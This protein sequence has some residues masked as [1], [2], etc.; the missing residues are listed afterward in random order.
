M[1][2]VIASDHGAVEMKS[3][4]KSLLLAEGHEVE[5]L[6]CREGESVDYPVIGALAAKAVSEGRVQRGV[7]LCGTGIGMSLVANRF[8]GVRATLV[9]DAYTARMSREHNDS[10]MLVLGGRVL[11]TEV[12]K[13]IVKIWLSTPFEG[14]RH[15]RRLDMIHDLEKTD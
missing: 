11:G 5:D 15:Q 14:G 13:D 2:L 1:K 6:G 4:V 9:H 8:A 10:N 7:L 3:L 12:A